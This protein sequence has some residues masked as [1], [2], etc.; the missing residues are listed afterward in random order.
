V[1]NRSLSE[2]SQVPVEPKLVE[3][4]LWG[5][6]RTPSLVFWLIASLL[7]LG[8]CTRP[9]L[10]DQAQQAWDN[11]DF[12]SAAAHY[13]TFLREHPESDQVAA[14][15]FRVATICARDLREYDRAISHLIRLLEDH[16][17]SPDTLMGRLRLAECYAASEKPNEAISEYENLLPLLSDAHEK[18]RLRLQI[19]ELYYEKNDL[20]QAVVEYQKVLQGDP[21]DDL[22]ERASLRLGQVAYLRDDLETAMSSFER[23]VR[24]TKDPMAKRVAQLGMVDCFERTLR[25]EEAVSLLETI[26][27]DPTVDSTQKAHLQK[28]IS[29]MRTRER[30]RLAD[31]AEVD[32]KSARPA[33]RPGRAT[34]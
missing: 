28:R 24:L 27:T 3:N 17:D 34:R 16:P 26:G 30:Q 2:R 33:R 1:R 6:R 15:R 9:A 32:W 13:E 20:R 7:L 8:G 31:P 12:A 21:P 11:D 25:F 23:V 19:A 4:L 5:G 14:I 22:Y 10:L 29:E 18:R